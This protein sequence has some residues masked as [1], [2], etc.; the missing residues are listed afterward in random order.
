MHVDI[1]HHV[2]RLSVFLQVQAHTPTLHVVQHEHSLIMFIIP[3]QN[4][5]I[6][7][8]L[9][10]LDSEL[11]TYQQYNYEIKKHQGS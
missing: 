11:Q 10:D 9:R 1:A 5:V 6:M 7:T 4:C 2:V 3:A 8:A